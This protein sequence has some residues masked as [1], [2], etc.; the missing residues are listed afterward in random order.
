MSR[1][2]ARL[3]WVTALAHWDLDLLMFSRLGCCVWFFFSID[4]YVVFQIE[5]FFYLFAVFRLI[6]C[7][8]YY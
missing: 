5:S 8:F 1:E 3:R 7:C 2:A 6:F 4:L